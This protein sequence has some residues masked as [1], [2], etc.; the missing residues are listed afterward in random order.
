[1][2]ENNLFYN[3]FSWPLWWKFW[4]LLS[5]LFGRLLNPLIQLSSPLLLCLVLVLKGGK[6]LI[7]LI[8]FPSIFF[9]FF[10]PSSLRIGWERKTVLE[11][12]SGEKRKS[13]MRAT[14]LIFY[15]ITYH[16]Y[17]RILYNLQH[18]YLNITVKSTQL[19]IMW[20]NLDNSEE[21]SK[22]YSTSLFLKH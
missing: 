3:P 20:F 18:K 12:K 5:F 11:I 22:F 15:E 6:P 8:F 10:S 2:L 21:T 17:I 13:E 14:R 7:S 1:M 19:I 16:T 4:V 9:F